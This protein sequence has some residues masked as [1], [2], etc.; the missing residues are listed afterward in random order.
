MPETTGL[1]FKAYEIEELADVYFFRPL[2]M[3]CAKAARAIR[4]TPTEVTIVGTLVG[5]VGG[6]ML[7]SDSLALAG[8][9][10][11]ILHG[12]LD[13]SDGQLARMTGQ[14]TELGRVL[15][16]VSGYFTHVSAYVAILLMMV[17]QGAAFDRTFA[18]ALAAGVFS[19][20]H[21]QLY[22]YQRTCYSRA[23]IKRVAA[24]PASGIVPWY[25]AWQRVL[26]GLHPRVEAAMAARA[27]D[28]RIADQDAARYRACFYWLV[29]GWN[30]L[31]DNTR[32]YAL[33]VLAWLHRLD[34]YFL[35]VLGPMN[36]ALV[37]LWVW[38]WRADTRFLAGPV[39]G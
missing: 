34:W 18:L 3:V 24:P 10:V 5:I 36:A 20:C 31:G 4:L 26:A 19:A 9:G 22:D 6:A 8:F 2:G 30:L 12:I 39:I 33:G 28:G 29:R 35:F 11:L 21:A 7:Y 13:S 25:E 14:I 1:A 23:V 37:A 27:R 15:D 17:H 38:E 32:F 16:G